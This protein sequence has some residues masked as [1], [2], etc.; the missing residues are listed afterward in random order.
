M[1]FEQLQ[2]KEKKRT[3]Q[4]ISQ[5]G[6]LPK[7]VRLRNSEIYRLGEETIIIYDKDSST[8]LQIDQD[9]NL[10][11]FGGTTWY[12]NYS[13]G[14]AVF[15][16][17]TGAIDSEIYVPLADFFVWENRLTDSSSYADVTD[18]EALD[19]NFDKFTNY[20][21]YFEVVAKTDDGTA[22]YQLY[23]KDATAAVT[24]SEVST[25]STS[26]VTARSGA[27]TAPSGTTTLSIQHKKTGGAGGN[28]ANLISARII[29]D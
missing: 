9:N 10:V 21:G 8:V 16:S 29:W 24:G 26:A 11:G 28:Y 27:F 17:V 15:N 23:D 18:T 5:R 20:T 1:P 2:G 22:Y 12:V 7:A 14:D 13:T 25:S 6:L 3:M 4:R 19:I